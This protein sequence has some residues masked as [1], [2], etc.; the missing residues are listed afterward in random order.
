MLPPL[1][2]LPVMDGVILNHHCPNDNPYS[3]PLRFLFVM[4]YRKCRTSFAFET[5]VIL[6]T[7]GCWLF[8]ASGLPIPGMRSIAENLAAARSQDGRC[9]CFV[10]Y[11]SWYSI[12][13]FIFFKSAALVIARD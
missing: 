4:I 12:K 5:R 1:Q 8:A 13:T 6:A 2:A 10:R 9:K 11:T 7:L 3:L